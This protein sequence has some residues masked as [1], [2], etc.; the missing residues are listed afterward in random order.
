MI[1][2]TEDERG[3]WSTGFRQHISY[4]LTFLALHSTLKP[5][6]LVP[7]LLARLLGLDSMIDCHFPFYLI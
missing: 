1:D 4:S 6:S 5:A 3:D 7:P 2:R